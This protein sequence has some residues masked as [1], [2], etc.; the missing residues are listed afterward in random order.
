MEKFN[1][2]KDQILKIIDNYNNLGD[3]EEIMYLI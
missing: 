1:E 3:I 2:R